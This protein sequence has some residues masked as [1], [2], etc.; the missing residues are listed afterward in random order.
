MIEKYTVIGENDKKFVI[1][2]M[3]RFIMMRINNPELVK[4]YEMCVNMIGIFDKQP[5]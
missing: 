1:T 5:V 3:I 4:R 2:C